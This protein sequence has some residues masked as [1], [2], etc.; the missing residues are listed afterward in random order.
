MGIGTCVRNSKKK[1]TGLKYSFHR[2]GKS[3][4]SRGII[5]LPGSIWVAI[6][7]HGYR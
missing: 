7:I 5:L 6:K 3:V 2:L 1:V 4:Y